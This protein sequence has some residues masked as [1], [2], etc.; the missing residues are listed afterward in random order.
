MRVVQACR[1]TIAMDSREWREPSSASACQQTILRGCTRR[2]AGWNG[3]PA[4]GY[5]P[6]GVPLVIIILDCTRTQEHSQARPLRE[7]AVA[8]WR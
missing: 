3:V 8:C 1:D 2:V 7:L 5:R 4:T 6:R